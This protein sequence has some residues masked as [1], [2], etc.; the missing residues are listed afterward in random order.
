M[1]MIAVSSK[2]IS[3]VEY[4]E[5]SKNLDIYFTNGD[6]RTYHKVPK[7]I[8]KQFMESGSQGQYFNYNI[9]DKYSHSNISN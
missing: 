6:R 8:Y 9:R 4:H 2:A 7:T 1:A 5:K 3:A